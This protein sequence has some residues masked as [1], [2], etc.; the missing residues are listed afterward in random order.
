M[1]KKHRILPVVIAVLMMF[2]TFPVTAGVVHA[3]E[4]L[5][6][7]IS[8]GSGSYDSVR[9]ARE[10]LKAEPSG[11]NGEYSFQWYSSGGPNG[12]QDII[13]GAT[14]DSF[15]PEPIAG[16]TYYSVKVT[17][18][19]GQSVTST[20]VKVRIAPTTPTKA[21][22]KVTGKGTKSLSVKLSSSFE[23]G[24]SWGVTAVKG[25]TI[26]ADP[27][28]NRLIWD[29]K[30]ISKSDGKYGSVIYLDELSPGTTYKLY[31]TTYVY[32]YNALNPTYSDLSAPITV[33]TA[34]YANPLK[35]KAK[36]ATVKYS[37][38][39]KKNQTLAVTKVIKF[40]KKGQGT[41]SYAKAS[42]NKK[43]TINKKTGKVTVKKGLKKGTYKVKVKVKA[44][45]NKNY[46]ASAVKAVTFKV[47]VK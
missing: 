27:G 34:K 7:S 45:G 31:A 37:K 36:T 8:P 18:G 6:V 28:M 46:K 1:K 19:N 39:K 10:A 33:T 23:L 43:I 22:I 12:Y 5:S 15:T 2:A 30:L 17:D 38:L 35:I 13:Q 21:E 42:G 3:A 41:I 25:N 24:E 11:G 47:K 44:A 32:Y 20:P 40:T 29:F 26:P 9:T 14:A 4:S 16:D